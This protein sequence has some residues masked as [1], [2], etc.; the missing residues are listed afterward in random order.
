MLPWQT[1][2]EVAPISEPAPDRPRAPPPELLLKALTRLLRPLIRLLIQSSVTFPVLADML[3]GLYIEVALRDLLTDPK[4]RTDSRV[5]LLT[6]VHRKEIRRQR[7]PDQADVEPAVVT[8]ASRIIAQWLGAPAYLG[9]GHEPLPLPR[10]GPPPSFEALVASV[11]R[12]VRPRAVLDEWLDQGIVTLDPDGRVILN[13]QAFLPQ[14]GSAAKVFYFARNLHDHI[15]AATANMLTAPAPFLDR[16][17]HY[18]GLSAEGAVELVSAGRTAA[19]AMLL[20][21]N[22]KALAIAEASDRGLA[23]TCSDQTGTPPT[24]RVNLGIYLYVED[25]PPHGTG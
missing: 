18:D 10:S 24:R 5:S 19:Q 16:G 14:Q 7:M 1:A 8:R 4:S 20:D 17:V 11:T 9:A 15:A 13:E 21:V 12:D 25:D 22:R 3:R 23:A 2:P 6:G